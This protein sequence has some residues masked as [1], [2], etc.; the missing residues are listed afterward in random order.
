MSFELVLKRLGFKDKMPNFYHVDKVLGQGDEILI[1]TAL[2]LTAFGVVMVYSASY[3]V[4]DYHFFFRQLVIAMIGIGV[5]AFGMFTDPLIYRRWIKVGLLAIIILMTLQLFTPIGPSINNTRRWLNL[6]I[7]QLQSSEI[8][9][10]MLIVYMARYMAD[11]PEIG[12]KFDRDLGYL[13]I[14]P[15]LLFGLT[16]MQP[17]LSSTMMLVFIVGVLLYLG[18][19]RKRYF[20]LAFLVGGG[21]IKL[22]IKPYQ[23]Q[24]VMDFVFN[25]LPGYQGG[26]WPY[27]Q[28]Q[29]FIALVRGGFMGGGLAQGCQTMRY[30]PESH[31][32]F[33]LAIVG[34][35]LG[36]FGA[37]AVLVA[38][39]VFLYRG[40]LII[41]A[42]PDNFGFLLGAG[43]LSSIIMY[44]FVNIGVNVGLLPITGLPLPFISAGGTSLVLSLWSVGVLWRLSRRIK[45]DD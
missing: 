33:I 35:E 21:L 9:R 32:D 23:T 6:G 43:L 1:V 13:M 27:Q 36:W 37:T 26:E 20:L 18:G 42:Q 30:L 38:F 29:G 14:T 17:D 2:T 24:R 40:Y 19:L 10:C 25:L 3:Y 15:V 11:Y 45:S 31:N 16:M 28:T 22:L 7:I 41:R 4:A 5:M 39:L 8:A 12:R 34:E 44:A